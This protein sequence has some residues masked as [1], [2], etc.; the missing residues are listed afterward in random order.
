MDGH[1]A[2][3]DP[4]A[5]ARASGAAERGSLIKVLVTGASKYGSTAE[6]AQAIGEELRTQALYVEVRAADDVLSLDGFYAVIIGSGVYAGHWLEPAKQLI[7][8]HRT[9]LGAR[10]VWLF[11]VGPL[12]DPPKPDEQS[13]DAQPLIDATS[14]REHR[15][16][17]GRLD[18]NGSTSSS[19][20]CERQRATS[21][22]GRRFANGH[23][24]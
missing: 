7:D 16:F 22:T 9:E 2:A 6:V 5:L 4:R 1:R 14:A 12:G 19:L 20:R 15:I 8:G 10:P 24:A 3:A 11:S 18:R 23:A 13:V 21:A 17:S